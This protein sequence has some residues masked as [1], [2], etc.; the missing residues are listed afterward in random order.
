VPKYR[1]LR[2]SDRCCF[3]TFVKLGGSGPDARGASSEICADW[4]TK[5]A[6]SLLLVQV[7]V[8][9]LLGGAV[10]MGWQV[11]ETIKVAMQ[12]KCGLQ[13]GAV[14]LDRGSSLGIFDFG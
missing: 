5:L 10:A 13:V 9:K 3:H 14:R 6:D 2:L 4:S 7:Y 11:M 1:W 8:A 12:E